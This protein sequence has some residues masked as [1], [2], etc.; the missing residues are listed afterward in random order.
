MSKVAEAAYNLTRPYLD[1]SHECEYL[2]RALFVDNISEK[3][4]IEK[5][6]KDKVVRTDY[7]AFD[8][9]HVVDGIVGKSLSP[10]KL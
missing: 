3:C 1:T 2:K 7:E 6:L 8:R 5:S 9:M 4:N 10:S